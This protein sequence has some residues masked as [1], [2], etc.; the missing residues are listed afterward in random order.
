MPWMDLEIL[1]FAPSTDRFPDCVFAGRLQIRVNAQA[2][3]VLP[4]AFVT[5]SEYLSVI[6]SMTIANSNTATRST[7][8]PQ[9]AP[10]LYGAR[11]WSMSSSRARLVDRVAW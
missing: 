7:R 5:L 11:S 8:A 6:H 2:A 1:I 9:P 4:P 3:H 10:S